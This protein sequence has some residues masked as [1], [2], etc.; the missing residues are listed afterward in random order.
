MNI[1]LGG[2]DFQTLTLFLQEGY[3]AL[4]DK[5]I[6]FQNLLGSSSHSLW[7]VKNVQSAPAFTE[8]NFFQRI[9]NVFSSFFSSSGVSLSLEKDCPKNILISPSQIEKTF[10]AVVKQLT[11]LLQEYARELQ[12]LSEGKLP[13]NTLHEA[14]ETIIQA[15]QQIGPWVK[16]FTKF[17]RGDYQILSSPLDQRLQSLVACFPQSPFKIS[18]EESIVCEIERYYSLITLENA[19]GGPLP[20][21]SLKAVSRNFSDVQEMYLTPFKKWIERLQTSEVKLSVRELYQGIVAICAHINQWESHSPPA[22]PEYLIKKVAAHWNIFLSVDKEHLERA[23]H[24]EYQKILYNGECLSIGAEIPGDQIQHSHRVF[25]VEGHPEW[26]L[27]VFP[28]RAYVFIIPPIKNPL[29]LAIPRLMKEVEESGRY[30][31][32]ERVIPYAWQPHGGDLS[33]EEKKKGRLLSHYIQTFLDLSEQLVPLVTYENLGIN[34]KGALCAIKFE[35]DSFITLPKLEEI[36]FKFSAGSLKMY[37]DILQN[38]QF[39]K[40]QEFF[41]HRIFLDAL[42]GLEWS[43]AEE[44]LLGEAVIEHSKMF[45]EEIKA[46]ERVCISQLKREEVEADNKEVLQAIY[47]RYIAK[48]CVTRLWPTLQGEI[49]AHIKEKRKVS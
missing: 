32:M 34:D 8:G 46:L 4:H 21:D 43:H 24:L 42:K 44:K 30:S 45:F 13:Q 15:Y 47:D 27:R 49:I 41:Y 37:Q 25:E 26:I 12:K 5:N 22:K 7:K 29:K 48:R 11:P 3:A 1:N 19:G 23:T 18:P 6:N 38:T 36:V 17:Y 14:R 2:S 39:W 9:G 35:K 10:Q 20:L 40:R 31:L 28:N 16:M 33:P